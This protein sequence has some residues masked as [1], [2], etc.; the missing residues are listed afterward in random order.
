MSQINMTVGEFIQTNSDII[1]YDEDSQCAYDLINK[2]R[3]I[4]YPVGEWVGTMSYEAIPV[5]ADGTFVLPSHLETIKHARGFNSGEDITIHSQIH[6][7]QW[8]RCCHGET[9]VR[10]NGRIYSPFQ[11]TEKAV[12]CFRAVNKQDEGVSV[13]VSYTDWSG[14]LRDETVS[15]LHYK[16]T[17][18]KHQPK[19]INRIEKPRTVGPVEFSAG[20]SIAYIDAIEKSPSYTVYCADT[21]CGGCVAI[22]AKKKYIPYTKADINEVIDINPE[23]LSSLIIAVKYKEGRGE[24]WTAQYGAAVKI[25]IDFLKQEVKSET[26]TEKGT[27]PVQSR[28]YYFESFLNQNN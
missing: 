12:V 19:K 23:A 24:N 28:D 9:L 14:S 16:K 17:R 4:A 10:I 1:G 26:S 18:L 8:E 11:L 3:I 5:A 13:R 7:S 6:P 25:A 2:A 20:C 27:E 21:L 15:L 22:Q